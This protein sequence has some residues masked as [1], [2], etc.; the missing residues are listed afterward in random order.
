MF[1]TIFEAADST[2]TANAGIGLETAD[3]LISLGVA[4]ALGMFLSLV[5]IFSDVKKK[6][7]QHFA[8]TLVILPVCVA[9]VIMLIGSDIAK[10]I[11]LG[12]VFALV[13]FRSVPGNSK[14]IVNVFF[15]MATGLACG[16]GYILFAVVFCV[17]IGAVYFLLNRFGYAVKKTQTKQ[18]TITIPENLNYQGAFDD[19]F[20][21]YTKSAMLEKVKTTNLG[22]LYELTYAVELKEDVNEK[23]LIDSLRCRN[24]NLNISLGIREEDSS[25]IL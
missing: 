17:S 20:E 21:E 2:S 14:D 12:G 23:L 6:Y 15:A 10:A 9:A 24:G 11:S 25:M 13:R 5:Y 18:L 7:S 8:F 16:V 1:T 19:L 22:T 4:L 3:I